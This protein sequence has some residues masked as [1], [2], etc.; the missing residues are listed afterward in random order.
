MPSIAERV[1][2]RVRD[3]P[4]FPRPGILFRDIT[5]LLGDP[6]VFRSAIEGLAELAPR[7][8]GVVAVESRGFVFGAALALHWS[9]PLVLARKFGK[10]PGPTIQE[11]YSLEYGDDRLELR[12]DAMTP[13]QRVVI[14]DDVLAT[15]GTAAA[16]ARLAERAGGRVDGLLFLIELIG[17]GGRERL[18]GRRVDAL[19]PLSAG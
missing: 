10:L 1:R 5:P 2:V 12:A 4:N 15:G 19:L 11:T 7:P 6:A 9:V 17:L 13:G 14:V 18:E 16:T 8:E 3:V